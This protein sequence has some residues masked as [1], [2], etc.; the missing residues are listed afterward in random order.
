MW[1]SFVFHFQCP[2]YKCSHSIDYDFYLDNLSDFH[3]TKGEIS[4]N[5]IVAKGKITLT[6]MVKVFLLFLWFSADK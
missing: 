5:N 6:A 1:V 4:V 3:T 2:L